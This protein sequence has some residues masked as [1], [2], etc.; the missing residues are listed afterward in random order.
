MI[1][2]G[3]DLPLDIDHP[4]VLDPNLV[5]N[6]D[7]DRDQELEIEETPTEGEEANISEIMKE[8]VGMTRG[9][10]TDVRVDREEE[11]IGRGDVLGQRE[12]G[13]G[14]VLHQSI[15]VIRRIGAIERHGGGMETRRRRRRRRRR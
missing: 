15:E 9:L 13:S 4:Q 14:D 8:G 3:N 7:R 6:L 10:S 11:E 1:E 2:K 5:L 12:R